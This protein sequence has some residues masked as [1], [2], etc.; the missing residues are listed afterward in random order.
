MIS[1]SCARPDGYRRESIATES[2]KK[3]LIVRA[4]Q[5]VRNALKLSARL[6]LFE[7]PGDH[8]IQLVGRQRAP[9]VIPFG[10]TILL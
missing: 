1:L 2:F 8:P 10:Y 6:E 9:F 3:T 7:S 5:V 4:Q